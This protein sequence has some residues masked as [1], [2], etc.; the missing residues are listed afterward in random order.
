MW[1]VSR[2]KQEVFWASNQALGVDKRLRTKITK[3]SGV[4]LPIRFISFSSTT[5]QTLDGHQ[6]YF[7]ESI[8]RNLNGASWFDS[9]QASRD[10]FSKEI[11]WKRN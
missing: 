6:Q 7:D 9:L 2:T 10:T 3:L 5:Q 11:L 1:F 8:E 4:V